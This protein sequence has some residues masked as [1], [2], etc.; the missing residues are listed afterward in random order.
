MCFCSLAW[1]LKYRLFTSFTS[2]RWPGYQQLEYGLFVIAHDLGVI[3]RNM[4][5]LPPLATLGIS[6]QNMNFLLSLVVLGLTSLKIYCLL[7]L[8]DIIASL[9]AEEH[10]W[11][12]M[13]NAIEKG[14]FIYV[15]N[16]KDTLQSK[17]RL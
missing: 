5:C 9:S 10:F 3:S 4:V 13:I 7:W 1:K 12:A 6:S 16:V 17:A 2:A 11:L 8:V 14:M 15:Y